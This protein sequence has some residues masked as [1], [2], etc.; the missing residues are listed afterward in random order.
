MKIVNVEKKIAPLIAEC[1]ETVKEVKLA[2]NESR[3]KCSFCTVYIVLFFISFTIN[4]EIVT[5]FVYL[6]RYIKKDVLHVGFNTC[7]QTIIKWE[8]PNKLTL[9]IEPIIFT[10]IKL[11]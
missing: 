6:Q 2:K 10:T 8:K 11:I 7:T 4:I 3:S 1:T 9:K 5:Y